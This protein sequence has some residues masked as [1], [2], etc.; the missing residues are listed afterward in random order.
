[1][2][3]IHHYD[4]KFVYDPFN[5][6]SNAISLAMTAKRREATRVAFQAVITDASTQRDALLAIL[7]QGRLEMPKGGTITIDGKALPG[8]FAANM[9]FSR[10]EQVHAAFLRAQAVE[11]AGQATGS[12]GSP[13]FN[14]NVAFWA[15]ESAQLTNAIQKAIIDWIAIDTQMAPV[16]VAKQNYVAYIQAIA[17]VSRRINNDSWQSGFETALAGLATS[18]EL[19]NAVNA[20]DSRP[21]SC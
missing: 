15:N 17:G 10:W 4:H 8:P 7:E 19:N 11:I 16:S 20:Y 21:L 12:G 3:Y 6:V 2:A 1:M 18:A 9:V 14:N 13:Q 5:A